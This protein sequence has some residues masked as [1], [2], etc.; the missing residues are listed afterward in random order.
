MNAPLPDHIRPALETV[1]FDDNPQR[2]LQHKYM[3]G[4]NAARGGFGVE[5]VC[6]GG[7]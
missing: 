5:P 3:A 1:T 4:G 7:L 6:E 2:G